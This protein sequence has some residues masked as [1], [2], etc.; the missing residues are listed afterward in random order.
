MLLR[1]LLKVHFH[2]TQN[3]INIAYFI[4]IEIQCASQNMKYTHKKLVNNK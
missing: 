3:V 1:L 4:Q 2:N